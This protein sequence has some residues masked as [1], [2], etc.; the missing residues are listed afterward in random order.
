MQFYATPQFILYI[1]SF[2]LRLS[3]WFKLNS[4]FNLV[5]NSAGIHKKEREKADQ[6]IDKMENRR[7]FKDVI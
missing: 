7:F 1:C 6:E 5:L 4:L 2:M 3:F